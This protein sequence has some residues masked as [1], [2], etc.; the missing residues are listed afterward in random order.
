VPEI[1]AT[2]G[3]TL[4]TA[5]D[6]RQAIG[7][8]AR[9]FRF[10][11]GYRE[12]PHVEDARAVRA[13]AA[14]AGAIVQ[15]LLDLPSSRPR[16]GIMQ[17]LR[18]AVGEH[19][20]FWDSEALASPPNPNR[21]PAVPLPGLKELLAKL[22]PNHEMWF[23]DGRLR[24]TVDE[25]HGS[26]VLARMVQGTLPLKSSNSLFL[27]DSPSA[28][29]VITPPDRALLQAF[30]AAKLLPEWIA[31]SLIA[32][33]RDVRLGRRAAREILGQDI[34]VM[35][36]FE[37]LA[38]VQCAEEI[39]RESDGIMVARGDLGLAVGYVGL[40]EVQDRLVAAARKA[41]KVAVVATQV[42]EVFAETGL[43]Q[44]SELSD[45]SLIARQQA[46]AVML[47]KETVYSPRP[48]E[49]IRLAREVLTHETRRFAAE[50]R[51]H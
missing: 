5:E 8:G 3:P 51:P 41:G 49:C 17:E 32:S 15:L 47:G 22:A 30:A 18:P 4:E 14:Q 10:P 35:A 21:A 44:R 25:I 2:I 1:M 34:R 26:S 16:T 13:A 20:L 12:R 24:F 29:R 50:A 7:A 23:C 28:F 43:P 46:H 6:L 39:I 42:L 45:L 27:P 33:P 40:P 11:C 36:K 19:V 37:T 9:W 38:A 31:L 48:I